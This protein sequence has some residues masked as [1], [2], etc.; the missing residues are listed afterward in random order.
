MLAL[1]VSV[2]V[3]TICAHIKTVV[4]VQRFCVRVLRDQ[5]KVYQVST[6][7]VLVRKDRI[8]YSSLA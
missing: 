4:N 7:R 3:G 2:P 5:V 6:D 1:V 8:H